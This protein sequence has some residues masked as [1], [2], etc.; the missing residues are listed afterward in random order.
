MTRMALPE[1]TQKQVQKTLSAY[2]EN[3]IPVHVRDKVRLN[4]KF[5][6]NSVTLFEERPA[7][8]KP[9]IWVQTM[10]AQFRFEIQTNKWALYCADRNSKWHLYDVKPSNLNDLLKEVDKDP[11]GIFWG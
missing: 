8:Q 7:F 3:R 4:F 6:G 10:I 11:T 5:S 2:C 1:L 9:E